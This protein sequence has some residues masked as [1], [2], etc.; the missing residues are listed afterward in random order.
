MKKIRILEINFS[1]EIRG[2]QIS[3]FRGSVADKVGDNSVLFHNHTQEG[4]IHNYP[5]I[6]YKRIQKRASIICVEQGV[7]EIYKLFNQP[8][9]NLNLNGEEF[10]M[11]IEK[12]NVNS[13]NLNV[14]DKF[15][16]YRI[17]NWMALNQ[18]NHKKF[19]STDSLTER[20]QILENILAANILSFAKGVD[21][22]LE[23][24]KKIEIKITNILGEKLSKYKNLPHVTFDV[25]FKTNVFIPQHIGLGKAVSHGYGVVYV[26]KQM[27]GS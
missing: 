8:N 10:E 25:E 19:R 11:K 2:N 4:F 24:D 13:F 5:Y 20:V 6:Q 23:E 15:F 22:I 21:W 27:S 12:L 3:A 14:W 26:A 9:W 7:D 18:E 1:P 17:F 16:S